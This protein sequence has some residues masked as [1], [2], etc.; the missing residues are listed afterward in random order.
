MNWKFEWIYRC[1]FFLAN[2]LPKFGND[3]DG[4]QN[5]IS[6][7]LAN[8]KHYIGKVY[9]LRACEYF[10]RYQ[11]FGDFPIITQPLTDDRELL[12]ESNKR[13]PRTEV[14]R[15]ILND[16][17]SAYLYLSATQMPTTRINKDAALL[18]KS[19][20]ALFEGTWLKYFKGTAFVPNGEGWPGALKDYN[21]SYQF[22]SGSIDNEINWF[23]EQSM[24]AAKEVAETYKGVLTKNTGTLQQSLDEPANPYYD[25]FAQED[26][27]GV[28]EV[29]LWRQ[30]DR[31]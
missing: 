26:L 22:Q 11:M 19:R 6:G 29:L 5:T 20:V 24:N 14:A 7:D 8:I 23:L 30:Y 3:L 16:L 17:D 2:V 4:S 1:N 25:M 10:K 21:A 18:L 31:G 27:S 28:Q 12:I 13:M 9:F 15:F